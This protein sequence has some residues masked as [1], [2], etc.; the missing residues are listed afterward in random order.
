MFVSLRSLCSAVSSATQFL[1]GRAL[2]IGE[3]VVVKTSVGEVQLERAMARFVREKGDADDGISLGALP[4]DKDK[5][6]KPIH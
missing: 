2:R 3:L 6:N 1:P 5:D 4:S